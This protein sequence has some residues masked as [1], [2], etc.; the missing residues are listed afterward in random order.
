[1]LSIILGLLLQLPAGSG[2]I[3]AKLLSAVPP[4]PVVNAVA[5]TT[6]LTDVSVDARGRV[7]KIT[8]VQGLGPFNDSATVAIKQWKFNPATLDGKPESSRVGV[9]TVFRPA[10][11]GNELLGGPSFGYKPPTPVKNS[12]PPVPLAITD[13]GY[14]LSATAEGVVIIDVPIDKNGIPLTILTIQ[15]VPQ[16]T[17][18][19]RAAIRS[20]RFMPAME[21]GKPVVGMLIVA[22]S[23]VRPVVTQ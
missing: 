15:D 17:D 22:V 10:A 23:F 1:M 8:N 11:F 9:L 7:G 13:P 14:P 3:P 4:K 18:I 5:G 16:F 12:H 6:V 2:L 20:W 19:T 21:S